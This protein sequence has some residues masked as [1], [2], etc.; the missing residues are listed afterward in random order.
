MGVTT[1]KTRQPPTNS[2]NAISPR[3]TSSAT[4]CASEFRESGLCHSAGV[5]W[6]PEPSVAASGTPALLPS[7][8]SHGVEAERGAPLHWPHGHRCSQDWAERAAEA[9]VHVLAPVLGG[10]LSRL[11][12][13]DAGSRRA[14]VKVVSRGRGAGW[15]ENAEQTPASGWSKVAPASHRLSRLAL[16]EARSAKRRF[17]STGGAR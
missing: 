17:R 2:T 14:C 15:V 10:H 8:D 9:W 11:G 5:P 3:G 12:S 4:A 13:R 6:S 1:L 16:G 7:G